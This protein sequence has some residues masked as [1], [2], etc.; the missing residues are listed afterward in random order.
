MSISKP[1]LLLS[2]FNENDL[3]VKTEMIS[4]FKYGMTK[5]YRSEL[6]LLRHWDGIAISY[7]A[8][9]KIEHLTWW[10]AQEKGYDEMINPRMSSRYGR[11]THISQQWIS[12]EQLR[13]WRA[14]WADA[15]NKMLSRHQINASIDHRTF[16]DQGITE[17]PSIHEGYIALN[18]EMKGMIADRCEITSQIAAD[19][20]MLRELKAKVA[21]LAD[22]C[23]KVYSNNS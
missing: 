7:Q 10:V 3:A 18:I 22:S 13:I 1:H 2:A 21:K 11:L 9:K 4:L 23:R 16:A 12:D 15:V 17:Q 20:K 14:N 8:G 6:K 19:N 5:V